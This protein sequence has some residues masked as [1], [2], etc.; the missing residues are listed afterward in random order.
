MTSNAFGLGKVSYEKG[1]GVV[2]AAQLL[3]ELAQEESSAEDGGKREDSPTHVHDVEIL[4]IALGY[5]SG[6]L[7]VPPWYHH[8]L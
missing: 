7:P 8:A 3:C 6:I 4:S 5:H 1:R 2:E